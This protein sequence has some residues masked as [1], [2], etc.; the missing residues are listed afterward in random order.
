MSHSHFVRTAWRKLV[1]GATPC[2]CGSGAA[3]LLQWHNPTNQSHHPDRI[4]AC[5]V[6]LIAFQHYCNLPLASSLSQSLPPPPRS[7][8]ISCPSPLLTYAPGPPGPSRG[9]PVD[10]HFHSSFIAPAYTGPVFHCPPLSSFHLSSILLT[11]VGSIFVIPSA[12]YTPPA[13]R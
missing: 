9:P 13:L 8:L 1:I 2:V 12:L 3:P 7:V 5:A 6:I 10:H 4:G 11:S